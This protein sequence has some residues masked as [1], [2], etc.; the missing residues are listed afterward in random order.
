MLQQRIQG[1]LFYVKD[2]CFPNN[3]VANISIIYNFLNSN[4]YGSNEEEFE[5]L[6]EN[7]TGSRLRSNIFR[8]R[9]LLPP[10]DGSDESEC[11]PEP[12]KP[13]FTAGE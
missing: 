7:G 3:G 2:L 4:V 11:E 12:D 6:R 1:K 8:D 9:E 10:E 13:C 5:H